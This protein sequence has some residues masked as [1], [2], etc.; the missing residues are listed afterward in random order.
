MRLTNKSLQFFYE[1]KTERKK[2]KDEYQIILN[3][4]NAVFISQSNEMF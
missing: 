1:K 4:K 3:F 2:F